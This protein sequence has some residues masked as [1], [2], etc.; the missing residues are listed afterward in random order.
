METSMTYENILPP[1]AEKIVRKHGPRK[2]FFGTDY[3]FAPIKKCI[4]SARKLS[5]LTQQEKEDLMGENARR[6]FQP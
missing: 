4:E 1:V 5:F 3:P 2:I 6:F